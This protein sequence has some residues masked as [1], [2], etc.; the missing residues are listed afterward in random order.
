MR[1]ALAV[2]RTQP[3][4]K[5]HCWI[6][7]EMLQEAETVIVGLGSADKS[8]TRSNPFT[9]EQRI[10]MINNVFGKRVKCIPFNDLGA[11]P[12]KDD[13]VD[14]VLGKI[15]QLNLPDPTDYYT[16]SKADAI[17]YA[18]RFYNASVSK[19]WGAEHADRL[20]HI[21]DRD[22]NT[23][24]PATEIRS[25]IELGSNDWKQ[26]VPSVNHEFIL[27]NYPAEFLVG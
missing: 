3:L 6:I 25:F 13:W 16:G 5:G 21:M 4:H 7:A 26:Y 14:Y 8:A 1:T 19:R 11:T 12:G 15:K 24:P 18:N 9:I 17:W 10:K 22:S 20:L 27:E 23:F 2:M